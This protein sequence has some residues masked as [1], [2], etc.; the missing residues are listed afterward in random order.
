MDRPA[1]LQALLVDLHGRL[2]DL[3]APGGASRLAAA[4]RER[5]ATLGRRVVVETARATVV[6]TAEAVDDDGALVVVGDDGARHVVV[7]G[8]V[9]HL[10]PEDDGSAAPGT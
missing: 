1:L 8:D 9:V 6:G 7:V 5:C 10:R 4:Y 2:L 3:Q